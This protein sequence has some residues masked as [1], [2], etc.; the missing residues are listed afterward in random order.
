MRVLA[1][2][3]A[4]VAS[5][6]LAQKEQ[7]LE[8]HT[9]RDGQGYHYL[10]LTTNPPPNVALPKFNAQ[11]W[12]ARWATPM[13]PKG[14]RWLC[15]D[16]SRKSGLYD[17]VYIDSKGD[18][19]LDDKEPISVSHSDQYNAYFDSVR[20]VF[21]GEDGPITYHLVL[22][23]MQYEGSDPR[24]LASSGGY[25]SGLVDIG[26]KK[27]RLNLID[28][29]VNGAFNDSA[30]DN[31][32]CDQVEVEND[33]AG[34]RYQGKLLEVD[35]QFYRFEAAR[36]GAFVKIQKAEDVEFGQVKVPEAV[37]QIVVFGANGQFTRKPVKGQ[38][39]LPAG[40]YR[41]QDWVID[42]KDE[43][44]T[45]WHL[46]GYGPDDSAKFEVAAGKPATLAVG[47]PVFAKMDAR[48][49]S[50]NVSFSLR[51]EGQYHESVQFTKGDQRPPGPKLTLASQNG[52]YRSTNTFEFG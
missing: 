32:D 49:T 3:A 45:A 33:K 15:F 13:D 29:N 12:F 23:Y 5:T 47:E 14:G 37:S 35:G 24:V 21:K 40:K 10:D 6:A 2:L 30:G 25:Y 16:R 27:R 31:A 52:T 7:W 20:V 36:D 44:G 38:F 50:G 34:Q 39:S 46:T 42:R 43:K 26:G 19:R 1:C 48:E 8:Y 17:R 41:V 9:S 18:G 22:R 11:P 51:F 4:T 28:G